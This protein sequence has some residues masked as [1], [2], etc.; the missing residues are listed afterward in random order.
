MLKWCFILRLPSSGSKENALNKKD[1]PYAVF[2]GSEKML[3]HTFNLNFK[4]NGQE[5]NH[6]NKPCQSAI[7][8]SQSVLIKM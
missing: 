8:I 2:N 4:K 7:S 1:E 5:K 6:Q 3:K